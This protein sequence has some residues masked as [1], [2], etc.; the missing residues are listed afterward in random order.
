MAAE[1]VAHGTVEQVA[2]QLRAHLRAGADHV[3]VQV[4]TGTDKLVGALAELA[5]PLGLTA[6]AA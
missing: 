4:L 1:V 6:G 3:P 5:G 2:A